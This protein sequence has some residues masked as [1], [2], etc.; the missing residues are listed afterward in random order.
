MVSRIFVFVCT[1]ETSL[2]R[3][4]ASK[5]T[6]ARGIAMNEEMLAAVLEQY[7]SLIEE[8]VDY[9]IK[10]IDTS[11]GKTPKETAYMVAREVLDTLNIT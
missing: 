4:H 5:L 9:P 2:D 8:L 1:P 7:E 3:E 11:N 6:T 10:K